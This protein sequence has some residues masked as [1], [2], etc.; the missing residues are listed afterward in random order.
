MN[1]HRS[2][3]NSLAGKQK[4]SPGGLAI[5]MAVAVGPVA[6]LLPNPVAT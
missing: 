3:V 2:C 5:C 6:A 4:T 1:Q